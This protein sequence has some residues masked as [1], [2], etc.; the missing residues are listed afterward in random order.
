MDQVMLESRVADGGLEVNLSAATASWDDEGWILRQGYLRW[1]EDDERET[2]FQFAG[3]RVPDIKE[4]PED[5]LVEAKEPDEMRYQ[6]LERF[7]RTVER[8]GGDPSPFMVGLAQKISLPIALF[9]I[10][11]FGAPLATT[12]KRGGTAFGVG[13]SLAVT[14]VYLMMFKVGEAVGE[15]G[16]VDPI[17]AAWAPNLLFFVAAIFLIWR[18]RT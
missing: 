17:L 15:S 3:M 16:A 14:M 1:L 7:I 12:S 11:L 2:T 6:E 13:V 8:S 18:V 10:V 5:L 4:R 9:V